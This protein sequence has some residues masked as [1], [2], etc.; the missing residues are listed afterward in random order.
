MNAQDRIDL[1]RIEGKID[2]NS[3]RLTKMEQ[4]VAGNGSG[5]GI[6]DRL[7]NIE[8]YI[9]SDRIAREARQAE[10][11]AQRTED[12]ER[13]AKRRRAGLKWAAGILVAVA[14]IVVPVVVL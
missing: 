2:D 11:N 14:G 13:K 6:F 5:V 4:H 10:L 12:M 9:E 8:G 1:A 7:G 3:A